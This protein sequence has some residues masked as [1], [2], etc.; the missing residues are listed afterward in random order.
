MSSRYLGEPANF[1][2]THVYRCP[3]LGCTYEVA[4]YTTTGMMRLADEHRLQH[5]RT[6]R[7]RQFR[8]T[9][10]PPKSPAEYE[11]LKLTYVDMCFL[12]TRGIKVPEDTVLDTS[13]PKPVWAEDYKWMRYKPED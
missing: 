6:D 13:K 2:P 5:Q 11:I 4:A 10:M 7:E 1:K 9:T 3:R 8:I 12:V